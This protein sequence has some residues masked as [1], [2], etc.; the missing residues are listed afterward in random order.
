MG[1]LTHSVGNKFVSSRTYPLNMAWI[2]PTRGSGTVTQY[3]N[4]GGPSHP[5]SSIPQQ[6]LERATWEYGSRYSASTVKPYSRHSDY[7]YPDHHE[8]DYP[9]ALR[10]Q[11]HR[12]RNSDFHPRARYVHGDELTFGS[13]GE[14]HVASYRYRPGE[15]EIFPMGRY[16]GDYYNRYRGGYNDRYGGGHYGG[17]RGGYHGYRGGYH[18]SYRGGYYNG[19]R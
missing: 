17:Y 13:Q 5:S 4:Y 6:T 9:A 11:D 12:Y 2:S 3:D 8:R 14:S 18:D 19:Y 1:P 16:G 10:F 7:Y 15:S